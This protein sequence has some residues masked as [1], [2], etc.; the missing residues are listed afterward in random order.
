MIS[1]FKYSICLNV[2][3]LVI[4]QLFLKKHIL[5]FKNLKNNRKV[6]Y[7]LKIKKILIT[8]SIK[9]KLEKL[10]YSSNSLKS[11]INIQ[12]VFNIFSLKK[13]LKVPKNA[14]L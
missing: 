8:K 5:I 13:E 11:T 7:K 10:I 6:L 4:K 9:L 3:K 14:T 2:F 1:N 12:N